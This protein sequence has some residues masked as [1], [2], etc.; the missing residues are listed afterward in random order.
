VFDELT[1][2]RTPQTHWSLAAPGH[3]RW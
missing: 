3:I 1:S 2:G